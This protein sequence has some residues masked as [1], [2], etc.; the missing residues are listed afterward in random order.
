VNYWLPL[1][2][3]CHPSPSDKD[4]VQETGSGDSTTDS[5]NDSGDTSPPC[6]DFSEILEE[7]EQRVRPIEGAPTDYYD[8][9]N[10]LT[11]NLI[12]VLHA[13][14][15][16]HQS[17]S[18]DALWEV[19]PQ[20][21]ARDDGTVWDV[22]SDTPGSLPSYSYEFETDR[23]GNY[24]HEGDCFNREHTWPSSWFGGG[25]PM[26]SDLFHVVPTD[27]YVNNRRGSRP[28]G[29]VASARWTS[30]NESKVGPS[31]QCG[32]T[33][34]V[35]E[36]RDD[37]KGDLARGFFYMAT[38][39]RGED[40]QWDSSDATQ[41]ATIE[42]WAEDLL[43]AW[44]IQDPVDLKEIARNDAV[45]GIQGNRNPFID[46]PEWVCVISDF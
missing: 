12:E 20:T 22:Y 40:S 10:E 15:D 5:N 24:Q 3:A 25:S 32:Y 8:G 17:R 26:K 45:Y 9:I 1:L 38:R 11:E 35:F 27:G 37:F 19:F 4:E 13:K 6:Q 33:R 16:S 7:C 18:F 23:C 29:V 30:D 39:Y 41:G 44:H 2:L 42:P 34:E 21:D 31:S 46:H 43:R 14:I 36:P 28:Y